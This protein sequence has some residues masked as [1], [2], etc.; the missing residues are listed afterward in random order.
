MQLLEEDYIQLGVKNSGKYLPYLN[1]YMTM[2]NINTP[3]RIIAF[4]M[5]LL[6]ESGNF[7]AIKEVTNGKAYEWN[8]NLGNTQKGDGLRFLGRGLGHVTGRWNYGAFSKWCKEKIPGFNLNFIKN[9]ELLE[10]P[11]WAVLSAIWYYEFKKLEAYAD[12]GEF[13]EFASIWNTGKPDS[14]KINGLEHRMI[15]KEVVERWLTNIVTK[16]LMK[17]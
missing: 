2:F 8:K 17:A 4:L 6:H 16:A 7:T 1:K 9:P 15:K 14:Q 10:Q 3:N 13:R 5:N 11:E 12:R